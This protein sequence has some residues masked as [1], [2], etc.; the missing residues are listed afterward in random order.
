M[1]VCLSC[2]VWYLSAPPSVCLSLSLSLFLSSLVPL[3]SN[4]SGCSRSAAHVTRALWELHATLQSSTTGAGSG[5]GARATLLALAQKKALFF[6]SW[7]ATLRPD[8][9]PYSDLIADSLS[10]AT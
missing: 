1:S 10:L 3:C 4:D 8:L 6:L 5:G 9:A 2:L 7:A